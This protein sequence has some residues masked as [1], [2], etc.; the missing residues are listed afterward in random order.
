MLEKIT[1]NK[2]FG[3]KIATAATAGLMGIMS[4]VGCRA[5]PTNINEEVNNT[6]LTTQIKPIEIKSDLEVNTENTSRIVTY[7]NEKDG[8]NDILGLIYSSPYEENWT[9]LPDKKKWIEIGINEESN[10]H[11]KGY[12]RYSELD[13]GFL[14][15]IM[16][17]NKEIKI[18]HMHPNPERFR[19]P[20]SWVPSA[21][22]ISTFA[23]VFSKF[24]NLNK[25]EEGYLEKDFNIEFR[26]VS[27]YGMCDISMTEKARKDNNY[28]LKHLSTDKIKQEE[29]DEYIIN[30]KKQNTDNIEIRICDYLKDLD[31][32]YFNYEYIS[33]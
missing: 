16:E 9:Y 13:M 12:E 31:Q 5:E 11:E 22:D 3:F 23:V 30:L 2:N 25:N 6:K 7:K 27:M 28:I 20:L 4:Y 14:S 19:N 10:I 32:G 1:R 15:Q 29:I 17:D 33:P 26:I 24:Y 18:Y 8:I 21:N